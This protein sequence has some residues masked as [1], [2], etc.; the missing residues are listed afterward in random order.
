MSS[1]RVT[2]LLRRRQG[3]FAPGE[4]EAWR[5]LKW[6]GVDPQ[7]MT[8]LKIAAGR[9]SEMRTLVETPLAGG[10]R[11]RSFDRVDQRTPQRVTF[12]LKRK[13]WRSPAC[14]PPGRATAPCCATDAVVATAIMH[15]TSFSTHQK[16]LQD[17]QIQQFSKW[18]SRATS[19]KRCAASRCSR[20]LVRTAAGLVTATRRHR[21]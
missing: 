16:I 10:G 19:R 2:R 6:D 3:A 7:T 20:G 5:A 18:R 21:A 17:P 11:G 14:A 8:D 9:A 1:R 12:E 15:P 4:A 13:G